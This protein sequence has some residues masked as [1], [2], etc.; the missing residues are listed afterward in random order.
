MLNHSI[1][2]FDVLVVCIIVSDLKVFRK[3][4]KKKK[5]QR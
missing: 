3:M 1:G 2:F 4:K 5:H